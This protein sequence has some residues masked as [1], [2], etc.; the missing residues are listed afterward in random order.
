MFGLPGEALYSYIQLCSYMQRS[1]SS[2]TASLPT[3]F[4]RLCKNESTT[5]GLISAIYRMLLNPCPDIHPRHSYMDKWESCLNRTISPKAW[6]MI[7][8]RATKTSQCI[9]YRENQIKLMMFWYHT[10][11]LLH[12]LNPAI[13]ELC[14]RC[15]G[16]RG[17]Q[18]HIFWECPKIT[19]FWHMVNTL[20]FDVLGIRFDLDPQLFLLNLADTPLPKYSMRLLL[21]ITTAARCLIALF[22]KRDV[23][24]NLMDLL[25]RLKHI[26]NM[27]Y[28]TALC[29]DRVQQFQAIWSLWDHYTAS[30]ES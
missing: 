16:G 12:K 29:G 18:I 27:E 25:S 2:T 28:L 7:W 10:P 11:T 13:P 6:Q 19:P 20:L 9:T 14:W 4:E 22:W 15:L 5:R 24:P 21:H 26:R 1:L 3:P 17:T 23:A 8:S 30:Q